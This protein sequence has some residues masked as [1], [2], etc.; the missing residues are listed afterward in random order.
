MAR[1]FKVT[2]QFPGY[3]HQIEDTN[4]NP[5]YL[6]VGSKNVI[7]TI[8]GSLTSRNGYILAGEAGAV[9]GIKNAFSY[10]TSRGIYHTIRK[11][12]TEMQFLDIDTSGTT[13]VYS[14]ITFLT[15]LA[16]GTRPD[17]DVVTNTT[18]KINNLIFVDGVEDKV[19]T[20]TGAVTKTAS[21]TATTITKEGTSTWASLGFPATG[22]VNFDGAVYAYTGGTT[23]TTLTG[24]TALPTVSAGSYVSHEVTVLTPSG[25]NIDN[26]T[27]DSIGVFRN[28]VYYGSS[29]S[30]IVKIS[31]ATAVD[32]F[33]ASSPRAIGD[34][35]E[36]NLDD[37]VQGFLAG[38]KSMLIFGQENSIFEIRYTA[39]ATQTT[40]IFEVERF[41]TAPQEGLVSRDAKIITL[42]GIVYINKEKTI[43]E[44]SFVQNLVDTRQPPLS[45]IIKKDTDSYIYDD[46]T[47]AIWDRHTIFSIPKSNVLLMYNQQKKFWQ[48]PVSFSGA[49]I[50]CMSV[51]EDG[52]LMGHDYFNDTSYILFNGTSDNGN[53]IESIAAFPY[54]NFGSRYNKK[55]IGTYVQD[56]Y[57]TVT[58]KLKL[59]I[60]F[61]YQ[62]VQGVFDEE[63][64]SAMGS[65]YVYYKEEDSGLGHKSLGSTSLSG[66]SLNPVVTDRR[67]RLGF[68]VSASEFYEMKVQYSMLGTGQWKLV[69]HGSDAIPTE[70]EVNDILFANDNLVV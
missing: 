15:G 64:Y 7:N 49:T 34:G 2:N 23:T 11:A 69:A 62:G 27:L 58:G 51:L 44:L 43:K 22:N 37:V 16:S 4:V 47:T 21:N 32:D 39:S 68:P 41:E 3:T 19:Y 60:D 25:L 61:E 57:I 1:K 9:G 50:G 14:W 67:F 66:S 33:G 70:T 29:K 42:S 48:P 45:D 54:N 53:N 10:R 38:K 8:E 55:K 63:I 26:Y 35:N 65:K 18:T 12:G 36:L 31:K 13:T 40:E 56:G 6:G 28:Q 17:F 5:D 46:A 24:L 30:T 59:H 52:T 20:W